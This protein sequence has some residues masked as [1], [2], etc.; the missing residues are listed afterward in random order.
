VSMSVYT[1]FS[2]RTTVVILNEP[3]YSVI[4]PTKPSP[5]D[6]D[7]AAQR[8][9]AVCRVSPGDDPR[10]FY[11]EQTAQFDSALPR[12]TVT[13][14]VPMTGSTYGYGARGLPTANADF[15]LDMDL[16]HGI[17]G[18]TLGAWPEAGPE[19][20]LL[21]AP[22]PFDPAVIRNGTHKLVIRRTQQ[23]GAELSAV[24][25]VTKV[26]VD[27]TLPPAPPPPQASVPPPAAPSSPSGPGVSSAPEPESR[28]F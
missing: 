26:T 21:H 19:D 9:Q 4:D 8:T 15:V 27:S 11:G 12:K 13:A 10:Q 23:N 28:C 2:D 5:N 20:G 17:P 24:L 6:N 14:I 16:H 18:T 22:T 7:P 3:V 25:L 1:R